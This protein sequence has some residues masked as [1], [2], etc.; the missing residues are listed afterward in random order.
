MRFPRRVEEADL[1]ALDTDTGLSV[2]TER[3]KL[4]CDW[5][6]VAFTM[7][8]VAQYSA[9][10]PH[11]PQPAGPNSMASTCYWWGELD[12]AKPVTVHIATQVQHWRSERAQTTLVQV[13]P[14][15]CSS[16]LVQGARCV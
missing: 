1:S 13:T 10:T 2:P 7:L 14:C 16:K 6:N 8:A 11:S 15:F 5:P 12:L 3:R 4:V 9:N